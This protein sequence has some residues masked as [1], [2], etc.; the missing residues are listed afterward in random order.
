[1]LPFESVAKR[2]LDL[3]CGSL[4]LLATAPLLALAA[5]AILVLDRQSP[6]F[7]DT[8]VGLGARG[9][10]CWK[11][12]TM[13]SAEQVLA[14]YLQK[15]PEE[16]E[17]YRRSR[18]LDHDP[19]ITPLGGLLRRA[20][21]DELPQLLNVLAGE[22]SLV[23]PRPVSWEE[24]AI[25]DAHATDLAKVKP[26]MTG[27]WQILGRCDLK[28]H[29]RMACERYYARRRSFRLDLRK[30]EAVLIVNQGRTSGVLNYEEILSSQE[31]TT[32]YAELTTSRTVLEAV[33]AE[34]GPAAPALEDLQQQ[35]SARAVPDTQLIVVTA[36][37]QD[38]GRAALLANAVANAFPPY[39]EAAQVSGRGAATGLISTVIVAEEALPP[40]TP[41]GP[42][43]ATNVSFGALLALLSTAV[44]VGL[45]EYNRE[46]V[47]QADDLDV[48]GV[49]ILGGPSPSALRGVGPEGSS[50]EARQLTLRLTLALER[51][52]ARTVL[53]T[54]IGDGRGQAALSAEVVQAAS[55]F[56]TRVAALD[57]NVRSPQLRREFGVTNDR[58]LST[59]LGDT[60]IPWDSL[61]HRPGPNLDLL[62]SGPIPG[63]PITLLGS[64]LLPELVLALRLTHDLVIID[65]PPLAGSAD[66]W[67]WAGMADAILLVAQAGQTPSADIAQVAATLRASGR[68]V[69]G[70]ALTS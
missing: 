51:E 40:T 50:E 32:T 58:G 34:L 41:S 29:R 17:R 65:G 6:I 30:A 4:A 68:T 69:V 24:F 43:R 70:L 25:R 39:V 1:M 56:A 60:T 20:S 12:R 8:R 35:V 21:I 7:C 10:G 14:N 59:A 27:L 16:A 61:L 42:N 19:R 57:G 15:H 5:L 49:P 11:L 63:D 54:S 67:V 18:K 47:V 45:V 52:G 23:G 66:A 46:R 44:A 22:M 2:A 53:L 55:E 31:L 64:E 48:F 37:A 33:I 9:F 28:E 26:G 13:R 3:V 38:P 36:R 62:T